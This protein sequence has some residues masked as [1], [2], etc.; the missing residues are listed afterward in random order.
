MLFVLAALTL[1]ALTPDAHANER[2]FTQTYETETLPKNAMEIEPWTTVTPGVYGFDFAHRLEFEVGLTNRLQTAFY[3]NFANTE[4]EGFHYEGISSEWKLKLLGR[5]SKPVGLALYLEAG[6]AP[7]ESALEGKVLIDKEFGRVLVA[8]NLVGELEFKKE[9]VAPALD[10]ADQSGVATWEVESERETVLEN[11]L[12]AAVLFAG[13]RAGAG[14]ELVHELVFEEGEMESE[15][16]LGPTL[17]YGTPSWWAA[18][19]F[20]P[21]VV[22]GP[23]EGLD[24]KGRLILGLSL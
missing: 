5:G 8:Y 14:A 23:D 6:L 18:G 13:K 16:L 3:L 24:W 20:L 11:K 4:D 22:G 15:M 21:V 9:L 17:S 19:S 12:A 1:T 10:T 7:M 2:R